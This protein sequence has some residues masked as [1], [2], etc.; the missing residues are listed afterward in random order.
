MIKHNIKYKSYD[1]K[2]AF[3]MNITIKKNC[4]LEMNEIIKRNIDEISFE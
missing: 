1:E 2:H 4:Y 3:Y